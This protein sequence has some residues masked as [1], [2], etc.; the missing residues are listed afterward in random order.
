MQSE[1][2]L[3]S[4]EAELIAFLHTLRSTIALIELLKELQ[5]RNIGFP[6]TAPAI[7]YKVFE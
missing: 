5:Q 3:S 2:A 1:V 6:P 7:H 4:T